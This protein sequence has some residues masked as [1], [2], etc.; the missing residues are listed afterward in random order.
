MSNPYSFLVISVILVLLLLNFILT[1]NLTTWL[2][3]G[4][5]TL[6]LVTF[7]LGISIG[8]IGEAISGDFSFILAL[9]IFIPPIII[10]GKLF[11]FLGEVV[12]NQAHAFS[13]PSITEIVISLIIIGI[14]YF[15]VGALI[16]YIYGKIKSRNQ[17]QNLNQ[18]I[19]T[20]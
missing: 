5:I 19:N 3:G 2:K 4:L 10:L 9:L 7:I 14:F 20:K 11:P 17:S 13:T 15:F 18:N 6:F 8:E 16:G 12:G 1:S